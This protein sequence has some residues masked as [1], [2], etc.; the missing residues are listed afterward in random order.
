MIKYFNNNRESGMN[1]KFMVPTIFIVAIG[2]ISIILLI[3]PNIR[4]VGMNIVSLPLTGGANP[5]HILPDT[6]N[7]GFWIIDQTHGLIFLYEGQ[8]S[9]WQ[10]EY[11]P[12]QGTMDAVGPDSSGN[13]YVTVAGYDPS[14]KTFNTSSG[15]ITRSIAVSMYPMGLTLSQNQQNLYVCGWAWPPLGEGAGLLDG[16][17]H[18]D[19]GRI[20]DFD[21]ASGTVVRTCV[22]GAMPET[23]YLTLYN[24][25]LVS[26][27]EEITVLGTED[28]PI[29]ESTSVGHVI[30]GSE[31][32]VDI[33]DLTR[34]ERISRFTCN[35]SPYEYCNTF[36][37]WSEDGRL[38]A[39]CNPMNAR[40]STR[41]LFLS[42]IW[43]IDTLTNNVV[44]T[45]QADGPQG[46]GGFGLVSVTP[47][48][49]FPGRMYTALGFWDDTQYENIGIVNKT[50][51]QLIQM[52]DVGEALRPQFIHELP[53]GRI[54][55]T[56]GESHKI[57]IIDPT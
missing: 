40:I 44:S 50:T 38:L 42:N 55:V 51:G 16:G 18:P 2:F 24:S 56:G 31:E 19:S 53:D 35:S 47:S 32:Y 3:L 23:V 45:I 14:I 36:I 13:L 5:Y 30:E 12:I 27:E 33:V 41:P 57:L 34:F 46:T 6:V 9:G 52:I 29:Y 10:T 26:T 17:D 20:L 21:I 39:M 54:I 48:S 22:V 4:A 25:L 1:K 37:P 7:N 8:Q 11:F 49:V 28:I 43:I 15:I